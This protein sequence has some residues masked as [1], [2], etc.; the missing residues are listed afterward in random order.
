MTQPNCEA[1]V[2][3]ALESTIDD[4]REAIGSNELFDLGL[5]FDYVAPGTFNDQT[6]GYWRYQLS[7]GGPSDEFRFFAFDLEDRSPT[8]EYWFLD[9]FDGASRNLYGTDLDLLHTVWNDFMDI[10]SVEHAYNEAE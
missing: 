5:G 9:W 7:W 6:E 3:G 2:R 4:I 1:R 8:V 10:G